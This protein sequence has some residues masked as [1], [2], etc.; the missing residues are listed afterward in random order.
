MRYRWF[1]KERET[2][3]E[4]GLPQSRA[5][6][7]EKTP[8]KKRLFSPWELICILL[9]SLMMLYSTSVADIPMLFFAVSAQLIILRKLTV[10][11]NSPYAG[12]L[13]NLL[14]GFSIGLFV[15]AVFLAFF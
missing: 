13:N 9:A 3:D 14:K 6:E 8:E 5:A 7:E 15:G 10:L 1:A 4:F 11:M 12:T 2:E